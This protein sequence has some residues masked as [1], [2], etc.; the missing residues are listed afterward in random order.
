MSVWSEPAG[1]RRGFFNRERG[2]FFT[3]RTGGLIELAGYADCTDW[4][5]VLRSLAVA[6]MAEL[7]APAV[8]AYVHARVR[9][10]RIA[11]G[12]ARSRQGLR[13]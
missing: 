11:W 7:M 3:V 5:L 13:R 2:L 9:A 8:V 12:R 10:G 1:E 6:G 4:A